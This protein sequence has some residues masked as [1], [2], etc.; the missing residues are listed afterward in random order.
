MTCLVD[1]GSEGLLSCVCRSFSAPTWREKPLVPALGLRCVA[2]CSPAVAWPTLCRL[3]FSRCPSRSVHTV[4]MAAR[5][6][7]KMEAK[8]EAMKAAQA[9]AAHGDM[10][11]RTATL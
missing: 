2:S 11:A 6:K 5:M 4:P 9:T 7:D 1:F 10:C 8:W 3:L